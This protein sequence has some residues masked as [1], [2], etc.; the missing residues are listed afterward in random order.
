MVGLYF[1]VRGLPGVTGHAFLALYCPGHQP[2]ETPPVLGHFHVRRLRTK[3][4]GV[5]DPRIKG[6][7]TIHMLRN[8]QTQTSKTGHMRMSVLL[9]VGFLSAR[10]SR[11]SGHELF[12]GVQTP[13]GAPRS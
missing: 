6:R 4:G 2:T 7:E 13:A 1:R 8:K 12:K 10:L 9:L 3:V 5:A 11:L